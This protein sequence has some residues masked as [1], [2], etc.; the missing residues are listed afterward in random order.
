MTDG[1]ARRLQSDLEGAEEIHREDH[2]NSTDDREK[3]WILELKAP[4]HGGPG[5]PQSDH[6]RGENRHR[7][8]HT[9]QVGHAVPYDV[10]ALGTGEVDDAKD[11][12]GEHRKN[13]GHQVEDQPAEKPQHERP[14]KRRLSSSNERRCFPR[15]PLET[16][17]RA[18]GGDH[19][20]R[21]GAHSD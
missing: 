9:R 10:P 16:R 3:T 15:R 20:E 18:Q 7:S 5:R 12:D 6:H 2:Q 13:A 19:F 11:L 8:Q 17:W 21:R 1:R 4:A 14:E